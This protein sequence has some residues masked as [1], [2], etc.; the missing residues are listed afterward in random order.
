MTFLFFPWLDKNRTFLYHQR[1]LIIS[2]H[3]LIYCTFIFFTHLEISVIG[4]GVFSSFF[5]FFCPLVSC[6]AN[7][8]SRMQGDEVTMPSPQTSS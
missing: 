7:T 3:Y 6:G 1:S 2:D 5:F 8:S 4:W